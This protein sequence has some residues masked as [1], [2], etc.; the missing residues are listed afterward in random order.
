MS[1]TAGCE[2]NAKWFWPRLFH[3]NE[4]AEFNEQVLKQVATISS[5]DKLGWR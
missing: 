2:T 1:K 3:Y 5:C 4:E